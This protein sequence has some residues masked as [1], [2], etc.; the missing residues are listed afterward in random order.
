MINLLR[1]FTRLLPVVFLLTVATAR[2][3][4]KSI[5]IGVNNW[6][7]NIAVANMWKVLLDEKGI[8]VQLQNADKALIYNSV[9]QGK[10]DLTFEV[11]LPSGDKPAFDKV[12]DRVV[13]IGPWFKEANLGLVVPDYVAVDSIDQLNANKTLFAS[14]GRP[15]IVGIDSGSS[16]M[17]LTEKAKTAY[18]LDYDIQSSSESAMVLS[19]ER[20]I[21]RKEPV[22]VTLWKPHWIWSKYKL[23]YLKDPKGAYGATDSIYGIET[24][25][26]RNQ[27][28][29]VERWLQQWKMDDNSL[30]GLM[31]EIIRQGASTPEKGAKAWVDANRPLV[32]Q[33]MK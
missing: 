21:Q 28:P 22:V 6:A 12:K 30:G 9:A 8:K 19:L 15:K 14:A 2:A 16:L 3:E 33:W 5:T 26:F 29:D 18:Q 23:K 10:I 17:Q 27:H 24:Q 25:A 13:Q 1:L 32:Q 31:S 20:A 11:W 7:E 4:D